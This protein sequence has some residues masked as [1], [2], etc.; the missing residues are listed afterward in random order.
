MDLHALPSIFF[1]LFFVVDPMG[2]IPFFLS[3]LAPY[4]SIERR[5]IILK[6]NIIATL[7]SFTFIFVGDVILDYLKIEPAAFAIAGGVLLFL[8]AIDMI[9]ARPA[10]TKT[11]KGGPQEQGGDTEGD[12][13]VFPLAIPMLSGPGNLAALIL[14][15]ARFPGNWTAKFVI[16]GISATVFLLSSVIL[17]LSLNMIRILGETGISVIHRM[18]GLILAA[19]S[20]QFIINGLAQIGLIVR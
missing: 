15:S 4:S 9:Y 20:I 6:S 8:I 12:V 11:G 13:S 16:A 7:V 14:F 2:L 17:L 5:R 19:L 1:T 10:R 18:M 3:T